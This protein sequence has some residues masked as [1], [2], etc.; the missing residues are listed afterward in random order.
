MSRAEPLEADLERAPGPF[1]EALTAVLAKGERSTV[2]LPLATIYQLAAIALEIS[3][4]CPVAFSEFGN[5][6]YVPRRFVRDIRA[7]LER[8]GVYDWRAQVR[9]RLRRPG[10][11]VRGRS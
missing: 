4:A 8:S 2:A 10:A 3:R 11:R 6:A 9:E 5:A 1:V 7:E